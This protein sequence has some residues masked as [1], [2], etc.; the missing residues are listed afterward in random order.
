VQNLH[1]AL[2]RKHEKALEEFDG[3]T[4]EAHI[5]ILEEQLVPINGVVGVVK[6]GSKHPTL[7]TPTTP[8]S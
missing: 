7:T 8:I 2:N 1:S 3:T 5:Q 6:V 4:V